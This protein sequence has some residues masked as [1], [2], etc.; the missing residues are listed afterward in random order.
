[1]T[2]MKIVIDSYL[3]FGYGLGV[4][5]IISTNFTRNGFE[6]ESVRR[7]GAVAIYRKRKA[8]WRPGKFSFEVIKIRVR[9]EKETSWGKYE[10]GEHYPSSEEW[11]QFGW[12]CLDLSEAET[13]MAA[14]LP[15]KTK[16]GTSPR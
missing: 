1:M 11:G 6:F 14:L 5:N 12:T 15:S 4:M 16:N 8:T 2:L 7:E 3:G 9:K 10:A 13:R